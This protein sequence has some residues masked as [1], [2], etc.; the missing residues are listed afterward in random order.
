MEKEHALVCCIN[1]EGN[2][3]SMEKDGAVTIFLRS[4]KKHRIKYTTSVG[5]GDTSSFA[6]VTEAL[7]KE[8]DEYTVVKEDCIEHIQKRGLP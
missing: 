1:H 3:G 5:D 8:Y 2:S 7:S 6:A 4:I